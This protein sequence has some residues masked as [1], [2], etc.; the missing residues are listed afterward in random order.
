MGFLR[1]AVA[2]HPW[3][4]TVGCPTIGRWPVAVQRLPS[5]DRP[6]VRWMPGLNVSPQR[7]LRWWN[8]PGVQ[9]AKQDAFHNTIELCKL[10]PKGLVLHF[11]SL[12]W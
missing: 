3:P 9:V 8:R 10:V 2:V 4:S 12:A 1:L 5:A 11:V 7:L 6:T